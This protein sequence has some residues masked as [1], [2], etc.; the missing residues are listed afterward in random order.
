MLYLL[1][2]ML[3]PALPVES[4]AA[5]TTLAQKPAIALTEQEVHEVW[6]IGRV[7]FNQDIRHVEAEFN[8]R[9]AE[10]NVHRSARGKDRRKISRRLQPELPHLV[11]GEHNACD[12]QR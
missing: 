4:L 7:V 8:R 6:C 3:L 5:D 2:L 1:V 9:K 10:Y 11:V 12:G